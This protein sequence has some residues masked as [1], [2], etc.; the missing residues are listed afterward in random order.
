[1]TGDETRAFAREWIEAWN[2]RDVERVLA[3][4]ADDIV[5]LSPYALKVAGAGRVVGKAALRAYWTKAL[6]G[7]ADLRFEL[8]EALDGH[9]CATILYTN[10][11]GQRV[12]ETCEFGGDGLVVRSFAC[13]S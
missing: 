8:V 9:D 6:A 13:Y 5:F 1:M 4:Y 11:R 12:A 10:Q 3:H 7:L 2:S